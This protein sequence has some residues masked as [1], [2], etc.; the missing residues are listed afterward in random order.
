MTDDSSEPKVVLFPRRWRVLLAD[1]KRSPNFYDVLAIRPLVDERGLLA[2]GD[3]AGNLQAMF[4]PGTW[5][6]VFPLP[7]KQE[8]DPQDD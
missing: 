4:A 5:V 2:F 3:N 8:E 6:S 7:L 1:T